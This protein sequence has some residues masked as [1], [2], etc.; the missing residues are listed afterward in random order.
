LRLKKRL[1][2]LKLRDQRK[3]EDDLLGE[4]RK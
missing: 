1:K 2:G 4:I 3:R